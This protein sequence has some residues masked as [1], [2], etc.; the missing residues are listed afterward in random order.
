MTSIGQCG[1][2]ERSY[3]YFNKYAVFLGKYS[4]TGDSL[5]EG[6]QTTDLRV[7][8]VDSAPS[9]LGEDLG[10]LSIPNHL[11]VCL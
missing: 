2:K 8:P 3:F 10:S 9:D 7:P 6:W 1:K 4:T 5:K 11:R